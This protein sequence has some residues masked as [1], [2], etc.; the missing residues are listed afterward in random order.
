MIKMLVEHIL[1]TVHGLHLDPVVQQ[2]HQQIQQFLV[3][4][5]VVLTE[6]KNLYFSKVS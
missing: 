4:T 1:F 3:Q 5:I 2:I 6:R